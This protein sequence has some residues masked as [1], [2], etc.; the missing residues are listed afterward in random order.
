MVAEHDKRSDGHGDLVVE[1]EK[2]KCWGCI[3]EGDGEEN[4]A[5]WKEMESDSG[6]IYEREVEKQEGEPKIR[7][8]RR[9]PV[10][11]CIEMLS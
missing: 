1:N 5:F 9:D 11:M 6:S 7:E 2:T 10:L 8:G 3:K 4:I